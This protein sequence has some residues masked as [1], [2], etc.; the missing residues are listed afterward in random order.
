[1]FGIF[2]RRAV[3]GVGRVV[4]VAGSVGL[5]LAFAAQ[6]AHA[7]GNLDGG[8]SAS[9]GRGG[10]QATAFYLGPAGPARSDCDVEGF[11]GEGRYIVSDHVGKDGKATVTEG[12]TTK[13]EDGS[14][15]TE[16]EQVVEDGTQADIDASGAGNILDEEGFD[17]GIFE[18]TSRGFGVDT[19]DGRFKLDDVDWTVHR[20]F[21]GTPRPEEPNI[22]A[23][24]DSPLGLALPALDVV[25][26]YLPEPELSLEPV[27][28]DEGWTYVQTPVDFRTPAETLQPVTITAD[29]GGPPEIRRWLTIT[30]E[31]NTVIFDSGDESVSPSSAECP[32]EMAADPYVPETPGACSFTYR[33]GSSIADGNVFEAELSITWTVAYE[34]SDG[35]SGFLDMEPISQQ[36]DVA[37][38]EI[39]VVNI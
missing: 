28:P 8:T 30:A 39:K 36:E 27:D 18:G 23:V 11:E 22:V 25:R 12:V 35:S 10:F 1:M 20:V 17:V 16:T 24:P 34:A 7:Q 33:N 6:L 19:V 3:G 31:P 21:C 38:A 9:A 14:R 32:A 15:T 13:G 4:A 37:V 5:V 2:G 26:G 29:T